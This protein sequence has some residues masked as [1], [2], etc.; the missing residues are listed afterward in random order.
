MTNDG[1]F[2]SREEDV[3]E[4]NGGIRSDLL[5]SPGHVLSSYR[6]IHRDDE[7]EDLQRGMDFWRRAT[8]GSS[9]RMIHHS[10]PRWTKTK[11]RR[12]N[13]L[14]R[15]AERFL[16]N[17]AVLLVFRKRSSPFRQFLSLLSIFPTF[18][19]MARHFFSCFR[20]DRRALRACRKPSSFLPPPS[21]IF[22]SSLYNSKFTLFLFS[23]FCFFA[24]VFDDTSTNVSK[25]A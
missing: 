9:S 1:A 2:E 16:S 19:S 20:V 8:E 3:R 25:I 22:R 23:F 13:K 4:T 14:C 18:N 7:I 24:R 17:R 15:E 5:N 21:P 11:R 12:W 10:S 6:V